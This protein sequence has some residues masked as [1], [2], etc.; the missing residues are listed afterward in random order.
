MRIKRSAL[1]CALLVLAAAGVAAAHADQVTPRIWGRTKAVTHAAAAWTR[2]EARQGVQAA[3]R[4][5]AKASDWTRSQAQRGV[6]TAADDTRE[7]TAWTENT[8]RHAWSA[9]EEGTTKA[10]AWS[11]REARKGWEAIGTVSRNVWN[12]A[13]GVLGD[14]P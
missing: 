12:R 11:K 4:D 2:H 13:K 3:R 1:F 10:M 7:T 9:T 5:A 14:R 8:I 6:Q